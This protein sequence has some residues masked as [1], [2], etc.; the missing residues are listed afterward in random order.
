MAI[1][2]ETARDVLERYRTPQIQNLFAQSSASYVLYEVGEDEDNFPQ[3]DAALTDK[4][5][6][7]AYALLAAGVSLAESEL[8]SE[9]IA[10]M[11]E[12][13]ALLN[14]V[15]LPHAPEAT[16]S[17][18]H[19]LI[20]SMAFYAAGQYSRAFV[21]IRRIEAQ[22][23]LARMIAFFIRKR[24]DE[25][26]RE[27]N[28]Y[29]LAD[30]GELSDPWELCDHAVTTAIARS[31]SNVLEYLASGE[32]RFIEAAEELVNTAMELAD[33]YNSPSHWWI[34]RLLRLMIRGNGA[35]SPW[36]VLPPHF[37]DG[38]NLLSRYIR[39]LLFRTP[40][41]TEL[42]RSQRDAIPIALDRTRGGAVVNMR[43]SSG[44]TRVA[45]MAILQTLDADPNAKVLYL[46]PF[47][48][49]AL[50]IEQ[51]LG[52]VFDWCGFRVSHL[53]G[54]FRISAI[55]RGLAE[56][57]SITIA[58]PEKARAILRSSPEL[59]AGVKLIVIDEGHLV[60]ANER[61]VRNELF[62]DHLRHFASTVD[63]RIIMLS[64]VLPNPAELAGWVTGNQDNAIRSEWKPSAE[65]FGV[66]RW[67]GEHV[68]IDWQGEFE[69][70][71]PRFVESQPLGWGRRRKPFPNTK[72]EAIAATA[73]RL[74]SVGPVMIFSARANSIPG[75]A[76]AVLLAMGESPDEHPWP[77]A[78]WN[79]FE[80]TCE[81]ELP[82][83][84]IELKAAR[85]GI[86]CHSNRLPTQ[87]RMA[88]ERLMRS[89][90]PKAIIASST[91]AQGVN[92]GVSSVI[93]ATPYQGKH[94]IDHR[95][96]W[97]ICGRAG[98]AFV[99]GEGKILYAIDETRK[100]WQ[101]RRD[102]ELAKAYFDARK[103]DP[104]VSGLLH[105]LQIMRRIA[106]EAGV[107]F[108]SLMTMVAEDQ[109]SK[110]PEKNAHLCNYILDLIDDGLLAMQEDDTINPN[111]DGPEVWV[112]DVFRG[113]L[114][115]IQADNEPQSVSRDELL[116]FIRTRARHILDN[117]PEPE[118]R[119]AV[120][121]TG[122]PMSAAS[123][124][125]RDRE[126]FCEQAQLV[127]DAEQSWEAISAFV[128]W[129][130]AWAREH[131]ERVVETLPG[132][133]KMNVVRELW[134]A[135][136]P[137]RVM[138]E[139][140]A[141]AD[142]MC[143]DIYGYQI[144]WLIHAASQQLRQMG[145]EDLAKVLASVALLVELGVPNEVA[146]WV[147]LTGVRSRAAS[148]EL[149]Y[150]GA[151]LGASFGE[152]RKRLQDNEVVEEL[153]ARVSES[154]RAW[155][156]LHWSAS[157][158]SQ[159]QV[160]QFP[161]FRL[162]ALA[163]SDRI[164]VRKLKKRIFLCSADGVRRFAVKVSEKWPCDLIADDDR[165]CFDRVDGKFELRTRDPRIEADLMA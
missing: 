86:V 154:T 81:E 64:A 61:Y 160:P 11:E 56:D 63:C 113:S 85:C 57:S 47:R 38:Q 68:R 21:S 62:V 22:T 137:M 58:T 71:N 51:S 66:L 149:A 163:A 50:E 142:Q 29:I 100:G 124:V 72:N 91:L 121:S 54:G 112:D 69:S 82:V 153:K 147:F 15:H 7:S 145:K 1:P 16:T 34:S 99:D 129:L 60:G 96:F 5:T 109:F 55:D 133:D 80:A 151:D 10:A 104:V 28:A 83:G 141:A 164:V 107:E 92:V 114:A 155:L 89:T 84:A 31:L 156:D 139:K 157:V 152:V 108:A 49:L 122:L 37:P 40:A 73:V 120:V 93:V 32:A 17:S 35:A 110:L 159:V 134:L 27:L 48:S 8:S 65:R 24:P 148:T 75:L 74:M 119:K 4:V 101:V 162:E 45:E 42:W 98:R 143:R 26:I 144:P 97:N 12:A 165:Y 138:C 70:F 78:A 9:S 111:G 90:A 131:A 3:F 150:C 87:V 158:C 105:V 23:D 2:V 116:Q 52:Q 132:E 103:A 67:Q 125:Y 20:S 127:A 43:T 13:A 117:T 59:L 30:L 6:M 102:H 46:A 161:K 106:L 53:Y 95:D 77:A 126:E 76:N 118:Q 130:E 41:V 94:P 25:L 39:L 135:G 19:V 128:A 140:V 33:T 79:V 18:F 14:N 136:K 44:K 88:T 36:Q 123:N 146:A 115:A